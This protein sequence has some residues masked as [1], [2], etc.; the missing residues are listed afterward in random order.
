MEFH[1]PITV[2]TASKKII[3]LDALF[4]VDDADYVFMGLTIAPCDEP[5]IKI[6]FPDYVDIDGVSRH[7]ESYSGYY[8]QHY[9]H[10]C[11]VFELAINTMLTACILGD[12]DMSF[13][14]PA[15][16]VIE[17]KPWA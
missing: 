7:L 5:Y 13:F 17:F 4:K 12:I 14:T 16:R 11:N 9:V 8:Q 3:Q 6:G 2:L 15:Q 10:Y 1:T